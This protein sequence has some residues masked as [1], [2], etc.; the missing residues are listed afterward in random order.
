[1]F[2]RRLLVGLL[3][4]AAVCAQSTAQQVNA[5]M[6]WN[7]WD[8]YGLTINEQQFR[9]NVDVLRDKL[10]PFGYNYAVIDEGWFFFNPEARSRPDTLKYALDRNGRYVPV[11]ARFPSSGDPAHNAT[12][13]REGREDLPRPEGVRPPL[14]ASIENTSFAP[15]AAWV[16]AQ[17]L[18]FG[19]H[20]VRGI[21]RASVERNLPL[22]GSAFHAQ[23]A[24][25]TNDVC[26]WDPTNWGV[27]DNAAGQAWYDSL[28]A[29]YA[30]W[31]VDL[32]K[33]DCIADHPYAPAEIR[34]IRRA[35][36]KTG[37]P[38]VLSLSPG[39]TNPAHAAEVEQ[40]ATMWRVSNDVWDVWRNPPGKD[41]PQSIAG[42][43]DRAVQWTAPPVRAGRFPDLDM[44]PF[45]ELRPVPGDGKARHTRLSE[46]EERTVM[47]LWSLMRSPLIIGANLTLLDDGTL[48]VLTNRE[49][50]AVAQA[51]TGAR[52][53]LHDGDLRIWRA[54]LPGGRFAV[55]LFNLGDQPLPA[56]AALTKLVSLEPATCQLKLV[57]LWTAAPLGKMSTI[58][59]HGVVLLEGR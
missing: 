33:V 36:D 7:S 49:V 38:M 50:L 2:T 39:P 32:L 20:I 11:A 42:Q 16:H 10:K 12:T 26:P 1:M 59:P 56:D 6:G 27:R 51:A 47:T 57:D 19:I 53:L 17:G 45:G 34:M 35:I 3:G 25:D 40:L 5:P 9:A 30:A 37:R 15:L 52:E 4:F 44:L 14:L 41:F 29:Q 23:D 24:A 54:Q 22:A 55:G 48:R 31:G 28:L 43:F 13:P 58:P 46:D 18:K 8:S 21:P